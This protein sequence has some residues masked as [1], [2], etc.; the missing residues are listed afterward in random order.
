MISGPGEDVVT[1]LP[2]HFTLSLVGGSSM[3]PERTS[4]LPANQHKQ[5][6]ES[7]ILSLV[8]SGE[9]AIDDKGR[10]WRHKFRR[11]GRL[12]P[13]PCRR[14]E[15][16]VPLGYLQVRALI[17]SKRYH[18]GA[19]RLVWSYRNGP[20]PPGMVVNHKNGRKD[21]NRPENLECVTPSENVSHAHRTGLK[22]QRG[23]RNPA[24]KLSD[25]QIAE[26]RLAYASGGITQQAL[27]VRYG[28]GFQHI[29]RL[30]KGKRRASQ[31]GPMLDGDLRHCATDR[32]PETGRFVG[33][34]DSDVN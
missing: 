1:I 4:A 5:S 25:H 24:A 29:S 12:Y 8:E 13:C 17:G 9:M 33:R 19:H 7:V 3:P 26:I 15:H 27:A 23:Q 18:V 2:D 14:A 16:R 28:V 22:D 20:I 11:N 6:A 10:I 21:D 30:V 31:L 34:G 32:D